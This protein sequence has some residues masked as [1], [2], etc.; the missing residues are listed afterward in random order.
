MKKEKSLNFLN[1]KWL[2]V[3]FLALGIL[4]FSNT[5]A[6]A[7]NS[8]ITGKIASVEQLRDSFA[9]SSAKYDLVQ[10][11]IDF[12]QI[13]DANIS[14]NPFY[15]GDAPGGD[16]FRA[17]KLRKIHPSILAEYSPADLASFNVDL[18]VETSKASPDLAAIQKL[19]WILA[20]NSY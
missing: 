9:P 17:D 15:L 6:N 2:M 19:Q 20:A 13:V 5:N 4:F 8:P 12:L 10:D 1:S 18:S 14:A 3:A 16:P 7:Q 11:A